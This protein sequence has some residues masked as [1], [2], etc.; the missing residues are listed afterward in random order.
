M[1]ERP[2]VCNGSKAD[3]RLMSQMGGKR[4]L[5]ARRYW[6]VLQSTNPWKYP[7]FAT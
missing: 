4:T 6:T 1:A 5:A 3:A 7:T 2:N